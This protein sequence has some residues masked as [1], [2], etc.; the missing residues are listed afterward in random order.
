ML[1]IKANPELKN[2]FK[3]LIATM[4]LPVTWSDIFV[5]TN[6]FLILAGDVRSLIFNFDTKKIYTSILEIPPESL[7]LES[8]PN[9]ALFNNVMNMTLYTFGKWGTISG[10]KVDKD[11]PT[12]NKL[13]SQILRPV[14]IEPVFTENNFRFFKNGVQIT[15]EDAMLEVLRLLRDEGKLNDHQSLVTSET[16][17]DKEKDS[18]KGAT[19]ENSGSEKDGLDLS[20]YENDY[21]I[22]LWHNLC[23]KK[24][25][26]IFSKA[27]K[28]AEDTGK[29]RIGNNF[30]ITNFLCPDCENKLY[31]GVYP[32][33]KELLI[34]TE[35]GR[36]FM[37]RTYSCHNCNIFYT[38]RPKKL[39]QEGDIYVL[40]FDEDKTAYEDYLD[41]LGRSAERTTNYKFNEFE[42][43]R[44]AGAKEEIA[45]EASENVSDKASGETTD[46]SEIPADSDAA[47]TRSAGIM[48]LKEQIAKRGERL[49]S[50]DKKFKETKAQKSAA[51]NMAA[52][53][54]AATATPHTSQSQHIQ[55]TALLSKKTTDELKVILSD[56]EHKNEYSQFKQSS[57]N[58][59]TADAQYIEAVRETLREK[60]TAKYDA[61]MG[62]LNN[63]ASRQLSDLKNQISKETTLPEDKK[64][65][66]IKGINKRLYKAEET[67]L[68][69]KVELSKKK[70]YT[71]IE[72]IIDE[73]TKRELPEELKQEALEKL[74]LIKAERANREV[75]NLLTHMPLHMDRKQLS[76]YLA[77]LDQYKEVDL[78]PYRLQ[79]EQRMDMAEKEEIAAMVKRGGKKDRNAMWN[80]YEQL[81]ERDYKAENKAPYLEKIYDK[82]RQMDEDAIE[83][84]CPSIVTLSFADG[85]KAYEEIE[86]G[87]FLPEI[88][89]NTLEMI[90]RRLTK[91]KTDECVQLMHKLKNDMNDKMSDCDGFY[92][93]NAR[94]EMK[95]SSNSQNVNRIHNKNKDEEDSETDA[96]NNNEAEHSAMQRAING[97]AAARGRYEYPIIICD[98]SRSRNGREG[99]V[100]TPDNIFYHTFLNSG[101]IN[102]LNID[103]VKYTKRIFSKGIFVKQLNGQKQKLPNNVK[104]DDLEAFAK[105][106]DDFASY[107]QEKPESRNIEYM[108]KEN[109]AVIHC[110]RCGFVY[111]GGNA[112]PKCGSKMNH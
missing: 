102:I 78:T 19:K 31:I 13:F 95:A 43:E 60:L 22:G 34:E 73:V 50:K 5:A 65:S 10:L 90:I 1:L 70:S 87:M 41:I 2:V 72:Q 80:L 93:Y 18:Q 62:V 107:L 64:E 105:I 30:Y 42:S 101:V 35:E 51:Q 8:M 45:K 109:H 55:Q 79:L 84:I 23:W 39:F 12:L 66:Y 44:N 97:Y 27:P 91:L 25:T 48:G 61:R 96:E 67:A 6:N 89:T 59:N 88:K 40:K 54:Q 71:E 53:N 68:E 33:G 9:D 52:Q 75:E 98:T 108:A 85:L 3:R 21:E 111:K 17:H 11:Y 32:E 47:A 7:Q 106:M 49:F 82:I 86:Q 20:D 29:S 46:N 56:L 112:C 76:V 69:Q 103:S 15:Y 110:Y 77:K 57:H 99:F 16:Q 26:R 37:A 28:T 38:P 83:R 14:N 36:V 74:N 63:L 58:E 24:D 4:K 81:Q 104:P 94:E 100:L 92:F